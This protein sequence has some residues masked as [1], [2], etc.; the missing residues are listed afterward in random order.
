[1]VI[2]E[3][4]ARV[5]CNEGAS[6][7]T[8][9]LT[10]SVAGMGDD[11]KVQELLDRVCALTGMGFAAV[12]YVSD[13]R[14]IACQ[15]ED[16]IAF[17]LKP[18]DELEIKKTL[19]DEIRASG[20][21]IAID[22]TANDPDWWNHPVPTLYGFRSYASLPIMIGDQ[23]FGTLCVIDDAPRKNPFQTVISELEKMAQEMASLLGPKLPPE[24]RSS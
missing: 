17:G 8:D 14:W 5:C 7:M 3:I 10:T 18:G 4:D 12:A 24:L 11:G 9:E 1:M 22:D 20:Q 6:S 16:R 23:F 19:C 21:A 13:K 15:V 2:G